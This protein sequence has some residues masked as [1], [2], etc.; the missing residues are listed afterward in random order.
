VANLIQQGDRFY[1]QFRH[2]GRRLSFPLGKV[3]R[4]EAEAKVNQVDYLLMRLQQGLLQLPPGSD[5]V[6]FLQADGK[7]VAPVHAAKAAIT[8]GQLRDKYLAVHTGALEATTT[9]SMGLH[10]RHLVGTF[11][12]AFPA[13]LLTFAELQRHADRRAKMTWR[14]KKISG[15]T[16]RKELVTLRTAWNWGVHMGLVEGSF[17][18]LKRVKTEKPEEKPPFMTWDEIERRVPGLSE[19]KQAELWDALYLRQPEIAELL[20][21]VKADAT[22]P[23]VYPLVCTAAYT[24]ARRSELMRMEINDV[25][26]AGET[27]LIRERKRAHDKKTTRRVSLT[28]AL[29][30]VLRD[31]LAVHPGS[32]QLFSQ[33][34]EVFR[35]KKRSKT[36]GHKD[37]KS[38][39]STL[40]ARLAGVTRRTAPAVAQVTKDEVHDHFK[41]SLRGSKWEKLKGLHTLRHSFISCLAAA[42]V[43]QRII[44]D[45]VGHTTDQQRQRYRHLFPDVKQKAISSVFG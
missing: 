39:P 15:A 16:I 33:A 6:A 26:F 44:D 11:G 3:P 36:T 13:P 34:G 17:P 19:E 41:R 10:F 1:C 31:W 12:E 25:D 37:E 8:V 24:G 7:A 28:P 35:S 2:H 14:G 43:D 45:F 29:A 21:Y 23:W 42:G 22:M 40:K 5:I 9:R 30:A 20:S 32:V 38:R 27:L 18:A 4:T